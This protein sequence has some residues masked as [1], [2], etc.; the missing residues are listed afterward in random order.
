MAEVIRSGQH[1]G[2]QVRRAFEAE[3]ARRIGSRYAF[4]VQTGSAAVHLSLLALG[5]GPHS[6][7]LVP[8]YVCVAVLNAV[9]AC[10]AEPLL[11]DIDP[12]FFNPREEHLVAAIERARLTPRDITAAV[13]PHTFGFPCDFTTWS[14]PFPIV[15]D[16]AM[17][18]GAVLRSEEVGVW[19]KIATFSFYATKMLST[20]HGGMVVT[21]DSGLAAVIEDLL[22][23]D[24][25]SEWSRTTWNYR[26]ADVNAALGRCQLRDL[27]A[28]LARRAAIAVHYRDW[29]RRR[30]KA[31]QAVAPEAEPNEFRFVIRVDD[32]A[33]W[34]AGL[35][36]VGIE[37]KAPVYRPLHHY[38]GLDPGDFPGTERVYD[39]ALSVPIYPSLTD[40]ERDHI[41]A[42]LTELDR[43]CD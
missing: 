33:V 15:E 8:S 27:D 42:A 3:F 35:A 24:S 2:G 17:A 7:V 29:A 4:A 1:A 31:V 14:F 10:G 39:E 12:E 19:G 25:R 26:L 43:V 37:A 9:T 13:V 23:Y 6:R 38:L 36:A 40:L 34:E 41:L 22:R 21:S 30:G 11:Y 28:F 32:R 5:A 18:A 20:G 16:C